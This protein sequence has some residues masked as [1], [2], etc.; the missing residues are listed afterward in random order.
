MTAKYF[1]GDLFSEIIGTPDKTL[2]AHVCNDKG[3]FGKG[4][5]S[6]LTKAF[7]RAKESYLEW[8]KEKDFGLGK[9]KFVDL[10][11]NI[12]VAHMV[13]QTLGGD[14]PLYYNHLVKCME[15]VASVVLSENLKIVAPLFGSNLAGGNV[16]FIDE[17]I[18]DCWAKKGIDVSIYYLEN[19]IP[20]NW[21]LFNETLK[22]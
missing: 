16:N 9:T 3:G 8:F 12:Q 10:G 5:V 11:N 14:R 17:L 6:S 13:A 15:E 18:E 4:F 7:P 21:D 22:K 20:K 19:F 2:I 1:E